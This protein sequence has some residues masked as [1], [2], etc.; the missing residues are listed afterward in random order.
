MK[1]EMANKLISRGVAISLSCFMAMPSFAQDLRPAPEYFLNTMFAVPM[2]ENLAAFCPT[3]S[4]NYAVIS[5]A[6]DEV[7]KRL[8]SDGFQTEDPFSE[9]QDTQPAMDA[10]LAEFMERHQLAGADQ[11]M[12]CL[13]AANESAAGTM[14]GRL[15]DISPE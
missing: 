8:T 5:V 11:K 1:F 12:V 10:K 6:H 4:L 7:M 3:A 9:M 14:V 13:A 2:A 15:L